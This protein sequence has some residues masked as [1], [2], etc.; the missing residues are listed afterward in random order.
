MRILFFI[1]VADVYFADLFIFQYFFLI[2]S[3]AK[4]YSAISFDLCGFTKTRI[5]EGFIVTLILNH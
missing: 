4:R 2:I 5:S 3:H 1:V